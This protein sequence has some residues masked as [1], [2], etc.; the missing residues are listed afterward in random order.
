[1]RSQDGQQASRLREAWL[2]FLQ[3]F[4]WSHVGTLTTDR[5]ELGRDEFAE[6]FRNR[7]TRILARRAQRSLHWLAVVEGDRHADRRTHLHFA[8]GGTARITIRHMEAAWSLG[9]TK[10]LR[11]DDAL[12]GL[13]YLSKSLPDDTDGII[14]SRRLQPRQIHRALSSQAARSAE[15]L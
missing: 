12:G 9:H 14:I 8:I 15:L 5:V 4:E 1:M 13:S 3:R 10:I 11:F 6:R 7:Y 2:E